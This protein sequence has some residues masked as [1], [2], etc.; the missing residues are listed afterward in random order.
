MVDRCEQLDEQPVAARRG[1][2]PSLDQVGDL[3]RVVQIPPPVGSGEGRCAEQHGQ[4]RVAV[5]PLPHPVAIDSPRRLDERVGHR[6]GHAEIAGRVG[7]EVDEELHVAALQRGQ[8]DRSHGG[9]AGHREEVNVEAFGVGAEYDREN[10]LRTEPLEE[11]GG[12]LVEQVSVAD[13]DH[14]AEFAE[15]DAVLPELGVAGR[16]AQLIDRSKRDLMVGG[17]LAK[18]RPKEILEG[19]EP[20]GRGIGAQEQHRVSQALPRAL[21][22]LQQMGLTRTASSEQHRGAFL[23]SVR[24]E[25]RQLA[26]SYGAP[27]RRR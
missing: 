21:C 25:R 26:G 9:V 2:E 7:S 20:G 12:H 10:P 19:A 4:A 8:L 16:P 22:R 17:S 27:R 5:A 23:G 14:S 6:F 18:Q 11:I 13:D 15:L 1:R 24:D 3:A